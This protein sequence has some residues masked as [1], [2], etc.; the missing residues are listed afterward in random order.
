M[1]AHLHGRLAFTGA[2]HA[3]IDVNGVGYLVHI[4]LSSY[5]KLPR[6]G[7]TCQIMTHLQVREDAHILYGFMTAE[8]R[9]LFRLLVQHVSGIGP[10][11]A[12]A[13]LSG[14][15]VNGFKANVINRDIAA[16]APVY[17]R[18][19]LFRVVSGA[20]G[21]LLRE[22]GLRD[23]GLA[24]VTES[25]AWLRAHYAEPFEIPGLARQ[26]NMAVTTFHRRFK[27]TTGLSP[28]Q[29]QKQLRLLEARKLL[30]Y[31]DHSVANAAF[32]VGYESPSQF[33]R[34]YARKFGSAPKHD[35]RRA[36]VQ[37]T[38]KRSRRQTQA[39]VTAEA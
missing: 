25:V 22:L 8:E 34:E 37:G 16:L 4:P 31:G 33:S 32:E 39:G 6:V 3:V 13:V 10:K 35:V 30:V 2:D 1:I 24:R 15:S 18:E 21:A 26:A 20:H 29:F 19:M 14:M 11:L 12:L 36:E 7:G 23:S 17:E 9:D 5:D 27:E 28:V 38:A